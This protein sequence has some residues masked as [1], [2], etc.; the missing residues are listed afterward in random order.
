MKKTT[1]SI[2]IPCYNSE[3]TISDVVT[4]GKKILLDL[5][6]NYEFVL[7][8]DNSKDSTWEKLEALSNNDNKV[9]SIDLARNFGQ[10]NALMTALAYATGDYIIGM[11]DDLQTSPTQIPI[12]IDKIKEGY[13][14]VFGKYKEKKHSL[15]RNLGSNFNRWTAIKFTGRPKE[16]KVSS[17]WIARKF[18]RDECV[19]YNGPFPH[20]Q[21]LFFRITKN[22]ADVY[23]EHYSRKF[24]TSNY[25]IKKLIKLWSSFTNFSMLPLR[26]S[27]YS[28]ITIFCIGI[29][30]AL[31]IIIKKIIIPSTAIGWTS[32]LACILISSGIIILI[33]GIIGEYVGR[34]FLTINQTPQYIIRQSKNCNEKQLEDNSQEEE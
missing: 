16:L 4:Q 2:I 32:I 9:K 7:V 5:G 28:G 26:F 22:V 15:F 20:L 24:G 8:N 29:I 21:G 3:K 34:I 33:L 27:F 6:Y 14:I 11:D 23:V 19:K 31:V 13:D 25:N 1:I 12:L 17:F 18:V 10:H 30:A